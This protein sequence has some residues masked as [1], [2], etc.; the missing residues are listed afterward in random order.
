[1]W[2]GGPTGVD[3]TI[4][5]KYDNIPQITCSPGQI[6]Q[7]FMNI[8]KNATAFI[9][10]ERHVW[11]TTYQED[12]NVVV[13]IRDDGKGITKEHLSKVFDP[14]FLCPKMAV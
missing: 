3:Y 14:F 2:K 9:E 13:K 1:M 4:H 5:K 11:I 12:D 8:L 6:N 10:S 7:V